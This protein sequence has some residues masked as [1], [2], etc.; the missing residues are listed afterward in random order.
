MERQS[1]AS[2]QRFA[3]RA[4]FIAWIGFVALAV[5]WGV[6]SYHN[7]VRSAED[8]VATSTH[9]VATHATWVYE[10]GVQATRR[11]ADAVKEPRDPGNGGTTVRDISDAVEGLPGAVKA[12]V[13][14]AEGHTLY[15]T[16]PDVKPIDITDRDYFLALKEGRTE[17]VS[18]LLISRLNN[19]RIF[20]FSRR[21]ERDGV[22]AGA[23]TVSL[24]GDIMKPIW[25]S[26]DLGG[27][28]SVGFIRND[29]M[30]VARYPKPD[31]ELDMSNHPLFTRYLKTAEEGTYLSE[32]SPMDGVRRLVGYRKVDGTP[33]IAI[34][35]ADYGLLMQPFW[36]DMAVLASVTILACLGSL[37][38]AWRTRQLLRDQDHQSA[39]LQ[40]ALENN[41]FL[42]RE[43]HHRVKNNLQSVMS[44]IRLH[45]KGNEKSEALGNRIKAMVAVHEQIYQR[46]S[47]SEL[48][49]AELVE[50]V[51]HNVVAAHGADVQVEFDLAPMMVSNDRA[52]SLALL[53]NELVTNSLKYAFAEG[54]KGK[55]TLIL[56]ASGD[57]GFCN[58]EVI[59]NGR[60]FDQ[61]NLSKGTGTRLI[62]G[63]IRQLDGSFELD[64]S[65]GT[66][67]KARIKLV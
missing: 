30:L 56:Q 39:A 2:A 32:V 60:G 43:V 42:L 52:T 44:L 5:T 20:V 34:A 13:V 67:F 55:L 19:D 1:S 65:A 54:E 41:E 26:V 27:S 51:T 50:T 35:A 17:Y 45:M 36:R 6:Q 11:I 48:D 53:V 66:R 62:E 10:L 46:D 61:A 59:D 3:T 47:F 31:R 16:D 18:S 12:Y 33:F 40:V 49:A 9:I 64:G 24:S 23:V 63:S 25:E 21:L 14:D 38:A 28:F 58:L 15:S 8:R 37:A 29:G 22:F 4:T 7:T 57:E